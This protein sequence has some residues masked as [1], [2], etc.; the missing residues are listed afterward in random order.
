MKNGGDLQCEARDRLLLPGRP[1]QSILQSGSLFSFEWGWCSVFTLLDSEY[2][3]CAQYQCPVHRHIDAE[4]SGSGCQ[5][6][7]E[8]NQN[9]ARRCLNRVFFFYCPLPS[10]FDHGSDEKHRGL[11]YQRRERLSKNPINFRIIVGS[12]NSFV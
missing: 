2:P 1:I 10:D 3:N 5:I 6:N 11:D 7:G 9:V 12:N 8:G 4:V